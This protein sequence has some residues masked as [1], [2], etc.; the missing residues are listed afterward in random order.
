MLHKHFGLNKIPFSSNPSSFFDS[1]TLTTGLVKLQTTL[2]SP[3]IALITGKIGSGKTVLNKAFI[4]TLDPT[5]IKVVVTPVAKPSPGSIFKNIAATAGLPSLMYGDDIKLQLINHFEE[6]RMQGK[7]VLVVLDECHTF[8]VDV[9]D[10]LKTFF[11][12]KRNFS[13]IL[14]GQPQITKTLR[15]S[16]L[17]PLKQRIS[18]FVNTSTLSLKETKDYVEFRMREA[19]ASGAS[20]FDEAAFPLIY[21]YSE[22]VYR[23]VDQLCFQA[24]T[25]AYMNK[26][27]I[28]T[29]E[30]VESAYR[31]LDYDF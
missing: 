28:I 5:E 20:L 26:N 17:L 7:S 30:T 12:T 15:M 10:Q 9:L 22:G 2:F 4:D 29:K 3:R 16:A 13:M 14:S 31:N 18:V 23:M 25:V 6:I 24:L 19:G 8:S 11:D 1:D 27:N 21:Q